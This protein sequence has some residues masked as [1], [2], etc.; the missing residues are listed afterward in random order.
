MAG[1]SES[2]RTHTTIIALL[3]SSLTCRR[4][5]Y[6]NITRTNVSIVDNVRTLHTTSN[7]RVNDNSTSEVA[8]ISSLTTCWV[9]TD[10]HLTHLAEEFVSTID[11][12]RDNLT[13]NQ[14]LIAADG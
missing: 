14:H 12:S 4:K 2:V 8:N 10:T 6:D 13:R 9:D 11:N 7:S 1:R 5:T 3:V